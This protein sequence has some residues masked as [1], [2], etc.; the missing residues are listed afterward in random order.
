MCTSKWTLQQDSTQWHENLLVVESYCTMRWRLRRRWWWY[1][2]AETTVGSSNRCNWWMKT[3]CVEVLDDREM[4]PSLIQPG[5]LRFTP[6]GGCTGGRKL[7]RVVF[8]PAANDAEVARAFTAHFIDHSISEWRYRSCIRTVS[9][10]DISTSTR[11][12]LL[13]HGFIQAL[14]LNSYWVLVIMILKPF[15]ETRDCRCWT[16]AHS[17]T[18]LSVKSFCCRLA[19]IFSGY[20]YT[21]Q[22]VSLYR[23]YRPLACYAFMKITG[24]HHLLLYEIYVPDHCNF[25]DA[26]SC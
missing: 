26:F 24:M 12:G 11:I 18:V 15:F 22:I 17:L 9:L 20:R 25:M 8:K 14:M 3:T 16:M 4:L 10:A 2:L 19:S 13:Q 23:T 21:M 1:D 6:F 5:G 7:D